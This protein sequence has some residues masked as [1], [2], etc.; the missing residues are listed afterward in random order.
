VKWVAALVAIAVLTL[1]GVL[2][3]P[4]ADAAPRSGAGL[5]LDLTDM[6][7]RVVTSSGPATLTIT[8]TLTNTGPTTVEQPE[9][10]VQRGQRLTTDGEL[11]DA[12]DGSAGTDA[13]TPQFTPLA[14]ALAP[15][16]Q[17]PVTLTLPLR[18]PA[19]T[20]LALTTTGVHELLVNV[21]GAPDGGDRARL[22]A[23]RLLLPVLSLPAA[24]NAGAVPADDVTTG[25]PF[26]LI[27]PI[28]DTPHRLSTIP[29]A[30]SLLTDD[31]LAASLA[32]GGRLGGLVSALAQQAPVGSPVRAATCVAVDPDLV[33]T[34]S[35]M[36]AGYDVL[37]TGG[38]ITAG[39]GSAVAGQWLTQLSGTTRGGCVI[40]L[41]YA[42]ADIVAL[43][44]GGLGGTAAAAITDGRQVLSALLGT[45]VV[46]GVSWPAGGVVDAA[47]LATTAAAGGR[48]LLLSADGV[49]RGRTRPNTGVVPIAGTSQYAVLTD[50]LLAQAAAGSSGGSD[51]SIEPGGAAP[52]SSPAGTDAALS[53]QDAIGALVFRAQGPPSADGPL[54][55]APPHRWAADGAGAG[56]LLTAADQLVGTGALTPAAPG[57][58]LAAGPPAGAT[59]RTA[60]YPLASGAAE[61]PA[62]VV[63]TI[64][65]TAQRVADLRS[66]AVPGSGVGVG[67]N[68]V[69]APLTRGLVRPA[70]ATLRGDQAAAT[71]AAEAG[72]RRIDD[73]R[74]TVRVLEPPSP[75]SLGTSDAPLPLTV[76]NGLPVTVQVRV[77]IASTPGLRVAPIAP[78]QI[79]PLGRRQVSVNA[80]VTRSGQF[81]VEA[82]VL[83][84][85]GGVLGPPSRL[86][87]RSTV[88]G[89]ITV[90]LTVVAGVLLV[91]LAVRRVVRRVRGEPG[92]HTGPTARTDPTPPGDG[93]ADPPTSPVTGPPPERA[94]APVTAQPPA[95]R[96]GPTGPS[97]TRPGPRIAP[98]Q[99]APPGTPRT[100]P[101]ARAPVPART[102]P[103][104]PAEPT[105]PLPAP[106]PPAHPD[107]A[108]TASIQTPSGP[109]PAWSDAMAAGRTSAVHPV[110]PPVYPAPPAGSDR[111][112]PAGAPTEPAGVPTVR[113]I[114]HTPLVPSADDL[115]AT[116][117]IPTRPDPP[118]P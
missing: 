35:A 101:P 77:Q 65:A 24:G 55:L 30:R 25:A 48:S 19:T 15:G 41:P 107:K 29:A 75:Y 61:I 98:A 11:R 82:S 37:G 117:R 63:A 76:A 53:T 71:A 88:Y 70:S 105:P 109:P 9:V 66:A 69:F 73:V 68:E 51:V 4:A 18:G 32:P 72:L 106:A 59:P 108:G 23:V 20:S 33:E 49:D 90:W 52:T 84:P 39:T 79:P 112:A 10:R 86:R 14:D 36:A 7:P 45:P 60:V 17:V 110:P 118:A 115:T 54:V 81:T 31:S 103:P 111:P 6:T 47:T 5:R 38:T 78:V 95:P 50:P 93:P 43:T 26:S 87:V 42:D 114:G 83:T 67:V 58:A 113:G 27:Y 80:Q 116:D 74:A 16:Q 62:A 22:A 2:F 96:P 12:L 99:P 57:S 64:R 104:V 8:G 97:P 89:T 92:R 44:R 28:A 102:G 94:E 1:T 40:A 100:A 85:D 21:N 56:A 13:V 34:A 91:V 46:P 3:G